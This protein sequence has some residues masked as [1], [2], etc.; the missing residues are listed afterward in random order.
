MI[1]SR[2]IVCERGFSKHYVNEECMALLTKLLKNLNVSMHVHHYAKLMWQY[3]FTSPFPRVGKLCGID[4]CEVALVGLILH[5][6]WYLPIILI[7]CLIL[8]KCTRFNWWKEN[9]ML[10]KIVKMCCCLKVV[11][12]FC[13]QV[14]MLILKD[15]KNQNQWIFV[16]GINFNF[17]PSKD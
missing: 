4:V 2:L 13:L 8:E 12:Q 17:K 9:S 11:L 1:S 16:E 5:V 15:F 3:K 10:L 7:M 6:N 14:Q